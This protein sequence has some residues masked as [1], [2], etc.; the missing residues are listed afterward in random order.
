VTSQRGG[1]VRRVARGGAYALLVLAALL[2]LLGVGSWPSGRPDVRPPVFFFI[3]AVLCA[4][5]GGALLLVTRAPRSPPS[6][7]RAA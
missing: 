2:A 3:P 5:A 6:P 4:A 7:G 1:G